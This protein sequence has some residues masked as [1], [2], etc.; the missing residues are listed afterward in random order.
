[1][2]QNSNDDSKLPRIVA[3]ATHLDDWPSSTEEHV[4]V[5]V[6]CA[7]PAFLEYHVFRHHGEKTPSLSRQASSFNDDE[8]DNDEDAAGTTENGDA[9]PTTPKKN[10]KSLLKLSEAKLNGLTYYQILG[11]IP[12]HASADDIK[13]AYRR[14]SLLYHPDKTGLAEESNP[15]F[16]KVQAAFETLS[17]P[18]KRKAYDSTALTFDDNIPKGNEPEEEF[19]D[20][21]RPVFERNLRFDARLDPSSQ[22]KNSSNNNKR[23]SKKKGH[24]HK[25]RSNRPPEI[26]DDS[27]PL[28]E[29]HA[30][31]DYWIHFESWRDFTLQAAEETQIETDN[32]ESRYEKRWLQQQVDKHAKALKREELSRITK[33]VERAMAADPRLRRERVREQEE[34]QRVLDERK[35]KQEEEAKRKQ[36]QEEERQREE[37]ERQK[38]EQ[39]ARA[40]MKVEREQQ[41]K[42][43]RKARQALRKLT[44]GAYQEGQ[45][46]GQVVYNSMEAFNDDLELLCSELTLSQLADLTDAISDA[47]QI[48]CSFVQILEKVHQLAKEVRNGQMESLKELALQNEYRKAAAAQAATALRKV[49][50]TVWTKEELSALAKGIKKFPPGGSNRWESI[51]NYI[52]SACRPQEPKSKEQCIDKYNQISKGQVPPPSQQ[53]QPPVPSKPVVPSTPATTSNGTAPS[54]STASNS[55]SV[56]NRLASMDSTNTAEDDTNNNN[57]IED[58]WTEEQDRKL[59]LGLAQYPAS[60]DKNDRWA[61]I[62]KGVPGKTKKQCVLRFKTIRDAIKN[63]K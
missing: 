60:M 5:E 7:G 58:V 40:V 4:A 63:K 32:A 27:T 12:S 19:Y 55:H 46:Q 53:H 56:P 14:A 42:Q 20:T 35:Q 30:F 45:E 47:D 18:S 22:N 28:E 8:D 34:K 13:K 39:E 37:E 43:L 26:G 17:D 29:V 24:H 9:T 48:T 51:A 49:D 44:L 3:L 16:L 41:K 38:A 31:Y 57:N 21:Y 23:S 61:C 33:L 54:N 2:S 59:Q 25:D 50:S 11:D 10:Q 6:E 62:A 1:M 52:N 36:Q 15:V